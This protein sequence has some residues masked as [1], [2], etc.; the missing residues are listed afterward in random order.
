M[1][2]FLAEVSYMVESE[3]TGEPYKTWEGEALCCPECYPDHPENP[4]RFCPKA[5]DMTNGPERCGK[6]NPNVCVETKLFCWCEG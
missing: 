1:D 6:I 2:F 3:K 5:S 4:A